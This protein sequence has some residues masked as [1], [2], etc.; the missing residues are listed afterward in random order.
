MDQERA[1]EPLTE[2]VQR[3]N[4]GIRAFDRRRPF[5]WDLHFT[6]F[7]VAAALIDYSGGGWR[8]IA[9][10]PHLPGPLVLALSLGLFV[11]LFWRRRHPRAALLATAPV[12]LL[13]AWSGASLQQPYF[14]LVLVHHIALRLPL[15]NLW[16]ATAVM[17]APVC[18][19]IVRVR[20]R[21]GALEPA[22]RVHGALH[23]HRRADRRHGPHPARLHRGPGGPRPP[24]G[25]RTR[26]AG[27]A[28]RRRRTRPHR[29]R[30]R[31]HHRPQP[32]RH[33]RTR[34]RRQ[35]RGGQV[36]R[37][38]PAQALDAIGS[39]SR[40]ALGEL[41]RLLDVLREDRPEEAR[42]T[43]QPALAD[44][45]RLLDGVRAAGL[46]V[47]TTVKGRPRPRPPAASWP[48]TASS[49]KPSPTP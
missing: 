42:R 7:W 40:Q 10:D 16:W 19:T 20:G 28:R 21:R 34:R 9:H 23:R 12:A 5:V 17:T 26:P 33:H 6:G 14:Q 48:S 36:P 11:P 30:I 13:N 32:L 15:R 47:R 18:V 1:A 45:D 39:T 24:P 22:A 43:P 44:L 29:P 37:T 49:R 31:R 25:G 38:A 41:R 46:P 4:R 27:P 35:V 2:Y 8:T 3:V